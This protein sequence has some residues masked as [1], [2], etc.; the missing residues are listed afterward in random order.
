MYARSARTNL[1]DRKLGQLRHRPDARRTVDEAATKARV[2]R[3][4]RDEILERPKGRGEVRVAKI[5][6]HAPRVA[7]RAR[8]FNNERGE[9][10]KIPDTLRPRPLEAV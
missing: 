10:R 7:A 4:E 3:V 2:L 1:V 5:R 9:L 8:A 6:V